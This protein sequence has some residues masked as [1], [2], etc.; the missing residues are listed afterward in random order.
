MIQHLLAVGSLVLVLHQSQLQ[1]VS[2]LNT[3]FRHF[4]RVPVDVLKL[5][6]PVHFFFVIAVEGRS[7]V[8]HYENDDARAPNI[9]LRVIFLVIYDFGRH[10]QRTAKDFFELMIF[11]EI[12]RKTEIC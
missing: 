2:R 7:P 4:W 6:L 8:Q 1:K 10:V 3:N 12:L 9:D 11:A 5:N